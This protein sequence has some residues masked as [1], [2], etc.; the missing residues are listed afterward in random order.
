VTIK[1]IDLQTNIG[2]MH[3]V[4]RGEQARSEAIAGQQHLREQEANE[5]S[6]LINTRLDESKKGEKTA[7]R[8]EEKK[9]RHQKRSLAEKDKE[10]KEKKKEPEKKVK[11]ERRGR[12]I[13][14]LK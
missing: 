1:P 6:N 12:I 3:E 2:Q 8:D 4:G 9:G 11:D 10:K 13:D 14:I 5:K 7:I